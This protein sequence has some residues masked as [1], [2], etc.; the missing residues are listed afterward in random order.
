M[1]KDSNL[2]VICDKE[3]GILTTCVG[4][5]ICIKCSRLVSRGSK[6]IRYGQSS[7][8]KGAIA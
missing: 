3:K 6:L 5:R 1:K 7:E 8:D 2:C 4:R